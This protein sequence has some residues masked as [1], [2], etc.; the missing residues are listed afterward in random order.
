[1]AM[2][3]FIQKDVDGVFALDDADGFVSELMQIDF[4]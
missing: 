4:V 2:L 3:L 1:M